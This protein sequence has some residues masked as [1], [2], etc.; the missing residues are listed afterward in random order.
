LEKEE[1]REH[2]ERQVHAPLRPSPSNEEKRDVK[3]LGKY[4]FSMDQKLG[5]GMSGDAYLGINT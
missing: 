5:S 3:R 2:G 1:K 4:E